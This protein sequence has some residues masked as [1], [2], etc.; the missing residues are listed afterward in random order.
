M[1][2]SFAML[3]LSVWFSLKVPGIMNIHEPAKLRTIWRLQFHIPWLFVGA[4]WLLSLG[5]AGT[6]LLIIMLFQ[7]CSIVS[8]ANK[9][10][11]LFFWGT[12][13]GETM[14]N[15]AEVHWP[16]KSIG[17]LSPLPVE[18]VAVFGSASQSSALSLLLCV[19]IGKSSLRAS[20]CLH[21]VSKAKV[22]PVLCFISLAH[23]SN[24]LCNEKTSTKARCCVVDPFWCYWRFWHRLTYLSW[25]C[26][27][28]FISNTNARTQA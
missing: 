23:L 20:I 18:V 21:A 16:L 1:I 13:G 11:A 27:P 17:I 8:D 26:A 15:L 7:S 6:D 2:W 22:H 19:L 5:S 3:G 4:A 24:A 9:V 14:I 25:L 28:I 12:R 10:R